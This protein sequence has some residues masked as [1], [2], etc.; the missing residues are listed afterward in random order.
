MNR[1]TWVGIS[2]GGLLT[3]PASA[4]GYPSAAEVE[5]L[6]TKR[7]QSGRP[8]LTENDIARLRKFRNLRGGEKYVDAFKNFRG[9][10]IVDEDGLLFY[11][12]TIGPKSNS[13]SSY[14]SDF[15]VPRTL[16]ASWR[17][18]GPEVDGV[19]RNPIRTVRDEWGSDRVA[20]GVIVGDYTV[21][22]AER[23][24]QQLLDDLPYYK[25]QKSMGFRLKLRLH[26]E[27]LLVGWDIANSFE[28]VHV[29]GDFEEAHVV[30]S[31]SL[32]NQTKSHVNGWYNHPRT[33]ERIETDF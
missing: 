24:P 31:G 30:Y 19:I 12:G 5:R 23:I 6:N 15:G 8:P 26:D 22:V 28:R 2:L 17:I 25:R 29:G 11:K 32:P 14:G 1:R 33:N 9:V 16:R 27:G 21:L 4:A 18:N 20:G 7:A 13:R 3:L 10:E